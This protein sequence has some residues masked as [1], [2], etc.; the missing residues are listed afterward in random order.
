MSQIR[1]MPRP[2]AFVL[3]GG[4]N[5]GATQVGMLRGLRR[6]GIAPDLIVGSSVG[7]MNGAMIAADPE[8]G[9][10]RLTDIWL[11]LRRR[12]VFPSRLPMQVARLA[13]TRTHLQS[14]SGLR[15]LLDHH[16]DART[17]EDLVLP[18][19][20][21]A[22]DVDHG[23]PVVIT[24]GSVADAVVAS[25][26]IPAVFP[27]VEREGRRLFDGGV[28]ANLPVHQA[29]GMGAG[30]LVVLDAGAPTARPN[31][32]RSFHSIVARAT[33]LLLRHQPRADL[34]TVSVDVPTLVLPTPIPTSASVFDFRQTPELLFAAEGST[35]R[36]LDELGVAVRGG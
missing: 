18:F 2:V 20:V 11:S 22:T 6:A 27:I 17:F 32:A 3:S 8:H 24:H 10:D 29:V 28:S 13:W 36:E 19:G 21:V 25:T 31:E 34:A 16:L 9:A 5:L 35:L 23:E 15:G 1:D 26:A 14:P 4:S 30:S 12:D 7:A 33:S